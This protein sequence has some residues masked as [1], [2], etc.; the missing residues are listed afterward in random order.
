[1]ASNN[2]RK[3]I[4]KQR[5]NAMNIDKG[6][7]NMNGNNNLEYAQEQTCMTTQ[8]TRRSARKRRWL[9]YRGSEG[10][11]CIQEW[12][13]QRL[14]FRAK[15]ARFGT[16]RYGRCSNLRTILL[17]DIALAQDG[18]KVSDHFWL[19]KGLWSRD[20]H[21]GVEFEFTAQ[22]R[23]YSK[24]YQGRGREQKTDFKLD[25]PSDVSRIRRT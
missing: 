24:G 25:R 16:R 19:D 7:K 4:R 12:E 17:V 1:M 23:R 3:R 9:T 18:T 15:V 22:V 21:Q 8:A 6:C 14:R 10:S 13:G 2:G 20:L 11:R 5:K